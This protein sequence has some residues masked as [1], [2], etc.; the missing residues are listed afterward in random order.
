MTRVEE[1]QEIECL[2]APYLS[3]D[4]PIGTVAEGCFQEVTNAHTW[5]AVLWQ[6]GFK[7]DKVVLFHPNFGGVFDEENSFIWG[8]ELSKNIQERCLP[9]S[10]AS[11]NQYVFASKNIGLKLVRQPSLQGCGLDEILDA[12]MP[13]VELADSQRYAIQA[14]GW[15]DC[16][17]PA[18]IRQSR[19]ED[20]SGFRN[21]VAQAASNVLH[22]YHQRFLAYR[23]TPDL[24]DKAS[25]L[26][27]HTMRRPSSSLSPLRKMEAARTES[28]A[29]D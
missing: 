1:L 24:F 17:N 19:V 12:E 20:R 22:C 29:S 8:N 18:S 15:N 16:G 5:Q 2:T 26:Y 10:C 9:R 23:D 13:G 3:E 27:K 6:P 25:L 14:A 28:G 4:D 21:V 11:R 7:A